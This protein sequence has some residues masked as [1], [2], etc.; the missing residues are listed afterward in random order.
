V[1]RQALGQFLHFEID[2]IVFERHRR[3]HDVS[4]D[5]T[6]R[7]QGRKLNFVYASQ[8]SLQIVFQN[9]MELKSLP[10]RDAKCRISYFITQIKFRQHLLGRE[11]ATG[12]FG[13][14]HETVGLRFLSIVVASTSVVSV[15]LLI[16]SMM[17]QKL[18][19]FRTKKVVPV[20]KFRVNRSS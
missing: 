15:V 18:N 2:G 17:F 9:S 10:S 11:P 6:A 3:A 5:V 4:L 19:A 12:D 13:S 8:R 7:G 1:F 20:N 14:N 16:Q